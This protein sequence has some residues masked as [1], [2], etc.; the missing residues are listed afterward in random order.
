VKIVKTTLIILCIAIF[1]ASGPVSAYAD[2]SPTPARVLIAY[3]DALIQGDM[4]QMLSHLGGDAYFHYVD[5]LSRDPGYADFVRNYYQGSSINIGKSIIDKSE[6]V[7]EVQI[8]FA[9]GNTN[10]SKFHLRKFNDNIWLI[11]NQ[12]MD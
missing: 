12:I 2:E 7:I 3:H 6:A 10:I 9:G 4:D 5:I 11:V 1:A 8:R